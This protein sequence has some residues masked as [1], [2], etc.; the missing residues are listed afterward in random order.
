[1]LHYPGEPCWYYEDVPWEDEEHPE[2]SG[3]LRTHLADEGI[4][5]HEDGS[6]R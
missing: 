3:M 5:T 2:W 4:F 6:E 1:M